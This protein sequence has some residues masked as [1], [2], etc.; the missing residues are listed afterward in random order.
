MSPSLTALDSVS[1]IYLTIDNITQNGESIA[2][3]LETKHHTKIIFFF[4]KFVAGELHENE[5]KQ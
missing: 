2:S 1:S 4:Y 5:K 3:K